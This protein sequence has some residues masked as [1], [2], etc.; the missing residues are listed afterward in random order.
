MTF[1]LFVRLLR[2]HRLSAF[3]ALCLDPYLPQRPW[4]FL[5][6]FL[7]VVVLNLALH[8]VSW[9]PHRRC[10]L[11]LLYA[12]KPREVT[13]LVLGTVPGNKLVFF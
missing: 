5:I 11:T 4:G 13:G 1:L 12:A 7:L 2:H 9:G 6:I 3:E 10:L 8:C